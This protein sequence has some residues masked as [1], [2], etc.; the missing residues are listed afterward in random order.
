MQ[1]SRYD[2]TG[3]DERVKRL[4]RAGRNIEGQHACNC[5]LCCKRSWAVSYRLGHHT[6]HAT[7]QLIRE[8]HMQHWSLSTLLTTEGVD[9]LTPSCLLGLFHRVYRLSR[10]DHGPL[11][12]CLA[13]LFPISLFLDTA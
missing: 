13:V 6:T 5:M 12:G 11:T 3:L 8:R 4:V 1:S 7:L 10:P 9:C 2:H